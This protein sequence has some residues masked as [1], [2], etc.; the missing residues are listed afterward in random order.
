M[1]KP[2]KRKD[3]RQLFQDI[4]AHFRG[5]KF[6]HVDKA[7]KTIAKYKVHLGT[8][9]RDMANFRI[10]ISDLTHAQNAEVPEQ[11]KFAYLK[12]LLTHD[13]R[14][15]LANALGLARFNRLDFEATI[16]LL[17]SAH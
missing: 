14:Q 6:H 16:D 10:Y 7:I 8:F 5:N 11:Q 9:E 17:I 13:T 12:E 15:C 4:H 1:A 3:P 2:V